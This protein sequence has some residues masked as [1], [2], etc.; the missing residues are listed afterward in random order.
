MPHAEP[1]G[2]PSIITGAE[3]LHVFA[4]ASTVA[5][6]ATVGQ[7]LL[8][9]STAWSLD[10]DSVRLGFENGG[11]V[12]FGHDAV[13][14]FGAA[15]MVLY[16]GAVDVSL[17]ADQRLVVRTPVGDVEV[18]GGET[19]VTLPP[20]SPLAHIETRTGKAVVRNGRV[21]EVGPD[22]PPLLIGRPPT[23][24]FLPRGTGLQPVSGG[25]GTL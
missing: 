7:V 1:V 10:G 24:E 22:D 17:P 9:G 5:R 3:S 21:I 11:S 16:R 18:L 15:S 12:Q 20:G 4:P 19:A 6:E 13:V 23:D 25:S 2:N 14:Q 8:P